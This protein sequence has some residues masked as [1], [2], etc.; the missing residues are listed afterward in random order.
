MLIERWWARHHIRNATNPTPALGPLESTNPCGEQPLL[1]Y[2]A[3]V[4]GSV[5]LSRF[6]KD[7]EVDYPALEDTVRTAVRFLDDAI[8]VNKYPLPEITRMH[9]GNRKIGLGVMGWA[10]MLLLL[11]IPYQRYTQAGLFPVAYTIGTDFKHADRPA[12]ETITH[13]DTW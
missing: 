8:D 2:E 13:F 1:P 9:T 7:G 5:E 3:C 6:V 11:G 10:D 12:A 4:L